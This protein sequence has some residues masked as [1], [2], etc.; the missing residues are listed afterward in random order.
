[1]Y[2]IIST[3]RKFPWYTEECREKS[4]R[5]CDY[6]L[7]VQSQEAAI[8]LVPMSSRIAQIALLDVLFVSVAIKKYGELKDQLDSVNR[9]LIDKR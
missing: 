5:I 7:S 4:G 2:D 1:M 9:S 6:Y 3:I 8:W